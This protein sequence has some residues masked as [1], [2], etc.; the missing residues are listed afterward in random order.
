[1]KSTRTVT[2]GVHR[3]AYTVTST[4]MALYSDFLEGETCAYIYK[5][6]HTD[7]PYPAETTE[8]RQKR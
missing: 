3:Y 6:Y 8:Y 5:D 7:E 4:S 1:M 2:G